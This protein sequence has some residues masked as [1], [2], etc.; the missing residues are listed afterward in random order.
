M[1]I[2]EQVCSLSLSPL[3][4]EQG[5]K[6]VAV[7]GFDILCNV[8][9]V[10]LCDVQVGYQQERKKLAGEYTYKQHYN[11]CIMQ[12]SENNA[13]KCISKDEKYSL[14]ESLWS[15]VTCSRLCHYNLMLH[16]SIGWE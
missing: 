7:Y 9:Y 14:L 13:M 5:E 1:L 12:C 11:V 10:L 8:H 16:V 6:R 2:M 4:S 3:F 15:T